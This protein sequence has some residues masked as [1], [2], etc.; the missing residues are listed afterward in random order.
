MTWQRCLRCSA[1]RGTTL[2]EVVASIA[3]LAALAQWVAPPPVAH[4]LNLEVD[5]VADN[6]ALTA[7][8]D[9][10]DRIAG[11]DIDSHSTFIL[12]IKRDGTGL[13]K[14]PPI[15]SIAGVAFVNVVAII[16]IILVC[17]LAGLAARRGF[18]ANKMET[19]D[20]F[21]VD[22]DGVVV[23]DH[24]V[25]IMRESPRNLPAFTF[26]HQ[27]ITILFGPRTGLEHDRADEFRARQLAGSGVTFL[28]AYCQ[29]AVCNPSRASLDLTFFAIL[30]AR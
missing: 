10:L 2:I 25:G 24:L 26:F 19:L 12:G 20:G 30:A 6:P 29:Q 8:I 28:R 17:Y 21:L 16:L 15:E 5:T 14:V 18:L 27:G 22:V 3:L 9:H 7:F 11:P 23:A 13:A 4:A 1:P